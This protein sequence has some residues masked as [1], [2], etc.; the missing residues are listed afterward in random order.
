M[1]RLFI[2]EG[3][4]CSGKSTMARFIADLTGGRFYDEGEPHPPSASS[5]RLFPTARRAGF[6]RGN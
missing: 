3:L 5:A 4:P 6:P 1:A 2:T